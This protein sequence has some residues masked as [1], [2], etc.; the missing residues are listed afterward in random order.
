VFASTANNLAMDGWKRGE[1]WGAQVRLPGGFD[2][3]WAGRDKRRPVGEWLRMGV[4]SFDG[5]PLLPHEAQASVLLPGA[6]A[7]GTSGEAFL[8]NAANFRAL[9]AYN[10]SDYYALCICLLADRIGA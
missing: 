4:V 1:P 6:A 7:T 10:P 3:A 9:R 5:R 2:Q 8:V